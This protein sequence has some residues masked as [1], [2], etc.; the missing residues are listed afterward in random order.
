M[1]PHCQESIFHPEKGEGVGS[2]SISPRAIEQPQLQSESVQ[3]CELD[4]MHGLRGGGN[5]THGDC[6]AS[7]GV[8]QRVESL[9]PDLQPLALSGSPVALG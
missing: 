8:E 6:W 1:Q 9:H 3:M 2:P 7:V 4:R 5:V